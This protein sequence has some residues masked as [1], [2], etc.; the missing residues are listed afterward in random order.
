MIDQAQTREF[1]SYCQ[2]LH[3]SR[4]GDPH[5]RAELLNLGRAATT[6]IEG[7]L[8]LAEN[9]PKA[10]DGFTKN[11]TKSELQTI[12]TGSSF[13]KQMVDKAMRD[14]LLVAARLFRDHPYVGKW[15]DRKE[16]PNSFIL[17]MT[18]CAYVLS[19]R[20]ISVGGARNVARE[21]I[22]NDM[23]DVM[24]AACGTYFDGVLT[25]DRKVHD[26]HMEAA[27]WLALAFSPEAN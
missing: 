7:L 15:P 25:A 22:R 20:W 24:F 17:R 19:L 1:C 3:E 10:F 23:V 11:Y 13:T 9:L 6:H 21:K 5:L 2:D 4:R 16:L 18:L 26:I 27:A 14:I 12:R 8:S